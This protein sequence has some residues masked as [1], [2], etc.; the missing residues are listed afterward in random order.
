MNGRQG[1]G[2]LV[3][4][5]TRCPALEAATWQGRELRVRMCV[6][7]A[8][9]GVGVPR[10]GLGGTYL[11]QGV[12]MVAGG[13]AGGGRAGEEHGEGDAAGG[14]ATGLRAAPQA[15]NDGAGVADALVQAVHLCKLHLH[16][17]VR[18]KS[19]ALGGGGGWVG[20][21]A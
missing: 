13:D 8:D 4:R 20:G 2:L 14:R 9:A 7:V 3:L 21:P 16:H 6:V 1:A 10:W 19:G 17:T 11:L 18:T 5:G 12:S 15:L